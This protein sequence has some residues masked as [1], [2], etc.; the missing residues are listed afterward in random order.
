MSKKL[1]IEEL[2]ERTKLKAEETKQK[3]K[4]KEAKRKKA[5][6]RRKE[7]QSKTNRTKFVEYNISTKT[8]I[9]F[10]KFSNKHTSEYLTS[11][12]FG[13]LKESDN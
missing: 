6:A 4:I 12:G 2:K 3:E 9:P 8:E 1:T 7:I 5:E 10:V 13:L 11:L